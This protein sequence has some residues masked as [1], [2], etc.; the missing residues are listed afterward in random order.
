MSNEEKNNVSTLDVNEQL[1]L[2]KSLLTSI[3]EYSIVATDLNG[4]ILSWN[5]GASKIYGYALSEIIGKSA[6]ILFTPEDLA[7]S[8]F[9]KVLEEVKTN[10]VWTG[11][12]ERVHKNGTRFNVLVTVSLRRNA[13]GLPVGFAAISRDLTELQNTLNSLNKVAETEAAL[14]IKN[15]EL[16]NIA[17]EA[18]EEA[19]AKNKFIASIS[20]ELRTPLNGI[21]G[22]TQVLIDGL[23]D[24]ESPVHAE[25]LENILSCSYQLLHLI[26]DVLDLAKIDAGKMEFHFEI[27]HLPQ[28]ISGVENVFKMRLMKKNIQLSVSIHPSVE[29]VDCDPEK[30]KQVL[31]N[32]ISNAIKF[33]NAGG[34]VFLRIFPHEQ[35]SFK[36]EVE[37]TGIGISESDLGKLFIEF[38]QLD[39]GTAKIHQGTGLGLAL[40]KR[41][42]EA[43]GGR[44][45]VT[46]IRGKGSTFYAIFP[47]TQQLPTEVSGADLQLSKMRGRY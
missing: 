12:M 42:I 6:R 35:N 19:R 21:M 27:T 29:K 9:D 7:S 2:F 10:G 43:Q 14:K 22:Y 1:D 47:L 3:H 26:N 4:I 20:H 33:T 18:K 23:V 8:K 17:L 41:I 25:F 40:T 24:P 13:A 36:L 31:Y 5:S 16:E 38:Q 11:E 28:L 44:V 37:D 45:G 15:K 34:Q 46:S 30:L 32:L 39:S